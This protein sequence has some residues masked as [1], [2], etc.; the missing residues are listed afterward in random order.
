[1]ESAGEASASS[2]PKRSAL[3]L[4]ALIWSRRSPT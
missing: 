4:T 1:M 2:A 3:V